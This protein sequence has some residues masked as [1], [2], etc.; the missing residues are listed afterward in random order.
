MADLMTTAGRRKLKRDLRAERL[1]RRMAQTEMFRELPT[2]VLQ[3][4]ARLESIA[5]RLKSALDSSLSL[6]KPDGDAIGAIETLRRVIDSQDRM[7]QNMTALADHAADDAKPTF[8]LDDFRA[9][10]S[11]GNGAG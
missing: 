10:N 8:D 1:A 9:G 4:Y 3:N 7:L 11:D 6:V 5:A 2:F